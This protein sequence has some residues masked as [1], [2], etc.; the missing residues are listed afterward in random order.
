MAS[1]T[2]NLNAVVYGIVPYSIYPLNVE[3]NAQSTRT[4]FFDAVRSAAEGL[5]LE[6]L[7]NDSMLFLISPSTDPDKE[8][9]P[10][11]LERYVNHLKMICDLQQVRQSGKMRPN[12]GFAERSY[13]AWIHNLSLAQ[14]LDKLDSFGRGDGVNCIIIPARPL[15]ESGLTDYDQHN[16]EGQIDS[17]QTIVLDGDCFTLLC[18]LSR[19]LT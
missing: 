18:C 4:Q 10:E 14:T 17:G 13:A 6:D 3:M 16:G 11:G 9:D 19:K 2:V 5:S 15:K 7:R 12:G 1:E 8:S